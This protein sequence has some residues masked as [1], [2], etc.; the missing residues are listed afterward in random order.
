MKTGVG[1]NETQCCSRITGYG[2]SQRKK[3]VSK[4]CS[5]LGRKKDGFLGNA[6]RSGTQAQRARWFRGRRPF[7]QRR[8]SRL[9]ANC[10]K[11]KIHKYNSILEACSEA[12]LCS[13]SQ[14]AS[15]LKKI[16]SHECGL[17]LSV[18]VLQGYSTWKPVAED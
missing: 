8:Q 12:C 3:L 16:P 5:D 15:L 1:D 13:I 7:A 9:R 6:W 17:R 10:K 11:T 14:V 4:T 18:R 2:A